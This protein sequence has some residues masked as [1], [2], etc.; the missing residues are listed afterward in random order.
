MALS[1]L[2]ITCRRESRSAPRAR[3]VVTITGS[4]SGVNP[5]ATAAANIPACAQSPVTNPLTASTIGTITSMNRIRVHP[6]V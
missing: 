2:T 3:L 1:R 6:T 5:T 4:I